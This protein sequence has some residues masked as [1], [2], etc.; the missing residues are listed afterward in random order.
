[1]TLDQLRAFVAIVEHGSI[2]AGARALGIA[3]SG[4]TQQLR[5]LEQ[6]LGTSLLVRASSGVVLTEHGHIL[7][8][9]ARII[10]GECH[11]TEQEFDYLK[12]ELQGSVNVGASSEA[13]AR[14]VPAALQQLRWAYPK[15][16]VHLASGPSASLLSGI[17]EGRLDFAVTLV[18]HASDMS[19][20]S[21]TKIADSRPAILCRRGHALA[22]A[23]SI[24]ALADAQW[25]N[26]RPLGWSGT[27]SNRLG[28]WFAEHGM[29]EPRIAVTVDSLL[30][31]LKLVA[32]TDY[33]FLGPGFVV[34]D[35]TFTRALKALELRESIPHADISLVQ[36]TAVPLAPAARV[37][38]AMLLSVNRER[39]AGKT[40]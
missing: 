3:Q 36:R 22:G 29:N 8:T 31:T 34:E 2:R 39:R 27:P 18:S 14:L 37:F 5:R 13:C 10:L 16:Q 21:S 33:L 26:T 40:G 6:S 7:L 12:G 11:R 38:A 30:D 35:G 1:M 20:L 9:R 23:T 28:D 15:V 17:R 25:I 19:D 24:H 4:L 32:E